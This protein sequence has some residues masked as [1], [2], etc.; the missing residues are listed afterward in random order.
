MLFGFDKW[1]RK[2]LIFGP[3]SFL[4]SVHIGKYFKNVQFKYTPDC[5]NKSNLECKYEFCI[6]MSYKQDGTTIYIYI[7][8]SYGNLFNTFYTFKRS[9]CLVHSLRVNALVSLHV[10]QDEPVKSLKII[11]YQ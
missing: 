8:H 3:R 11:L 9:L 6:V 1:K 7:L 5:M 2:L 10:E 4:C